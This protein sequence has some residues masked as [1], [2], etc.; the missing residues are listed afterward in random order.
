LHAQNFGTYMNDD[1]VVVFDVH[2]YDEASAGHFT[3]DVKRLDA[4]LALLAWQQATSDGD[5]R[6]P[7]EAHARAD[8][9][10]VRRSAAHEGHATL[11]LTLDTTDGYV[12]DVL[13]AAMSGTRIGLLERMTEVSGA[14]RRFRDRSGIRRLDDDERAKVEAAYAEYL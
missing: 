3:W 7:S 11:A 9:D 1:G 2:D 8:P 10:E 5:I 6:R 12:R 13:V 14:E 4:R